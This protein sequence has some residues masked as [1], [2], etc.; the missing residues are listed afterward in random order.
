MSNVQ[1]A[2]LHHHVG[3]KQLIELYRYAS[4]TNIYL[5]LHLFKWHK[6]VA[7]DTIKKTHL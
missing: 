2:R 6:Y 3:Q 7:F 1:K 5:R 4:Y